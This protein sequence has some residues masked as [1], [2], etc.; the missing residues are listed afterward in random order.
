MYSHGN[1]IN[2]KRINCETSESFFDLRD[3]LPAKLPEMLQKFTFRIGEISKLA[4]LGSHYENLHFLC[5]GG[6]FNSTGV[7]YIYIYIFI[8]I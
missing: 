6:G 1:T 7:I 8:Y 4:E 2:R 5:D 3:A